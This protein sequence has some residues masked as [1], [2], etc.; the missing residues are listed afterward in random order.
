MKQRVH[1]LPS[2][3]R[4]QRHTCH[5]HRINAENGG[6][7]SPFST[8][9]TSEQGDR[10][11]FIVEFSEHDA[12]HDADLSLL[13]CRKV[14]VVVH[15]HA[16]ENSESNQEQKLCVFPLVLETSFNPDEHLNANLIS[17]SERGESIDTRPG[18]SL[19][20]RPLASTSRVR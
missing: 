5:H 20:R 18:R 14:S 13:P 19:I 16:P 7:V 3:E 2:F 10:R 4:L 15:I 12:E 1:L 6:L 17:H 8:L 9:L 11:D